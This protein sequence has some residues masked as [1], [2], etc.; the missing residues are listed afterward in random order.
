[1][2]E[3]KD[4]DPQ[5]EHS[6]PKEIQNKKKDSRPTMSITTWRLRNVRQNSQPMDKEYY[7]NRKFAPPN[8][9]H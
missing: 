3:G 7:C 2:M 9:L 4:R 6:T 5:P 8:I 1:M